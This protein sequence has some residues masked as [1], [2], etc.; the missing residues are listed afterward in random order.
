MLD[1][2][3]MIWMLRQLTGKPREASVF[4]RAVER[5]QLIVLTFPALSK[6]A[7]PLARKPKEMSVIVE[8]YSLRFEGEPCDRKFGHVQSL[9]MI[10]ERD[11]RHALQSRLTR[12]QQL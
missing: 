11:V 12:R 5:V 8:P 3:R 2:D 9:P 4:S 6:D 10:F 7:E 1:R